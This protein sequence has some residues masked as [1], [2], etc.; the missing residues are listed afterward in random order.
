M[1]TTTGWD[2]SPG[3][4]VVC[5]T[6]DSGV[7]GFRVCAQQAPLESVLLRVRPAA[8]E[9]AGGRGGATCGKRCQGAPKRGGGARRR[10]LQPPP[11]VLP[12]AAGAPPTAWAGHGTA[13]LFAVPG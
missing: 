2:V 13:E 7:L 6:T 9:E 4:E 11:G 10:G 5:H 12:V 3:E 1:K 8:Q